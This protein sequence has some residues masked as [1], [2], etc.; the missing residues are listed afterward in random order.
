DRPEV[1]VLTLETPTR[2]W[3]ILL[4]LQPFLGIGVGTLWGLF[5]Y[6][7]ERRRLN[8]F[9]EQAPAFPWDIPSWGVMK[10][11]GGLLEVEYRPSLLLSVLGIYLI[12]SFVGTMV[13]GLGFSGFLDP[14]GWAVG[15]G[16]LTSLGVAL[17]GGPGWVARKRSRLRLDP[18][19]RTLE[20]TLGPRSRTVGLGEI[21]AV[22]VR[23]PVRKGK[24]GT[25]RASP[26]L[27]A[28]LGS[29]EELTLHTFYPMADSIQVAR[30][31]GEVVARAAGL[32][33][34]EE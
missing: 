28:R 22:L 16:F 27:R 5:V 6:F 15:A 26:E 32:P 12:M 18:G 31:A 11:G 3:F 33:L 9:L 34:H 17:I 8:R 7:P 21:R 25:N 20:F 13:V 10:G 2:H 29:G 30:K 14:P 24:K 4:F 1:A 19:S 23:W